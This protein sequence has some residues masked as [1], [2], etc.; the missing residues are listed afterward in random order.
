MEHLSQRAFGKVAGDETFFLGQ[1]AERLR[2]S[3]FFLYQVF[4]LGFNGIDSSR[5][6]FVKFIIHDL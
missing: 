3:L 4:F 6:R 5:R 2:D 1:Q